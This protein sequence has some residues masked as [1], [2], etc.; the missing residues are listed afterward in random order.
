MLRGRSAYWEVD[1]GCVPL[2][3]LQLGI[4]RPEHVLIGL[5]GL[6]ILIPDWGQADFDPA[7]RR[8]R[9][10]HGFDVRDCDLESGFRRFVR[11]D[12]LGCGGMDGFN[13]EPGR[14]ID[15]RDRY[16][17]CLRR[18][19]I[20]D[21]RNDLG[22][23]RL[24]EL[25]DRRLVWASGGTTSTPTTWTSGNITGPAAALKVAVVPEVVPAAV[26]MVEGRRFS[27]P[28]T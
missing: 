17:N 2:R 10:G 12:Q 20:A 14:E 22:R 26:R 11:R 21:G 16:L 9:I 15:S 4:D 3:Q 6:K 1:V 24:D 28:V 19:C 25:D 18:S 7:R 8:G 23:V 13:I 5:F 27:D